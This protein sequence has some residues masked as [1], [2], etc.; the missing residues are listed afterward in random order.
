MMMI[1][2]SRA[3]AMSLRMGSRP[4]WVKGCV[5]KVRRAGCSPSGS[6]VK[7]GLLGGPGAGRLDGQ[8]LVALE[9]FLRA[10]GDHPF[11]G[12]QRGRG[13]ARRRARRQAHEDPLTGA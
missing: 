10:G 2:L 8:G 13:A 5:G 11:A 1:V 6:P 7:I 12:P 3:Q 4:L 9:K